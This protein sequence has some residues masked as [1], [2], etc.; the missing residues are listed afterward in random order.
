MSQ[1]YYELLA[2]AARY[3][4]ALLSVIIVWRAASWLRQD[5]RRR[6]MVMSALPDAGYVGALYVMEGQS[7]HI[8]PGDSLPLPVEGLLGSGAGCDVRVPHPTVSRR[9]AL[10]EFRADGLHL[11]PHRDARLWV[12]GQPLPRGCEAILAHGARLTL[13]SVT[14]QLRLF[15]GVQAVTVFVP[16]S[17]TGDPPQI[18]QPA[19]DRRRG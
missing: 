7:K 1:E 17:E 9:H 8:H 3:A 13:G 2:L 15:A 18:D 16:E 19:R 12:D 10:F 11:R 14:L 6:K 4:F 5:S